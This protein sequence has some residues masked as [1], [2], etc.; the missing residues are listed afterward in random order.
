MPRLQPACAILDKRDHVDDGDSIYIA[1]QSACICQQP[2]EL[3]YIARAGHDIAMHLVNVKDENAA[4]A[5][6][7]AGVL[8]CPGNSLGQARDKLGFRT[9]AGRYLAYCTSVA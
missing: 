5:M 9:S 1:A 3:E 2:R 7:K 4:D 6:E 8:L